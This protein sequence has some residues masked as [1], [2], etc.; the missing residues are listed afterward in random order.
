MDPKEQKDLRK[1]IKDLNILLQNICICNIYD[2]Y[3]IY[4]IYIYSV[5]CI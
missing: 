4:K 3:G 5:V 1:R 2:K